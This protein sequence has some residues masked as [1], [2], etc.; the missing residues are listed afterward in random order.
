MNKVFTN[1]EKTIFSNKATLCGDKVA[2]ILNTMDFEIEIISNDINI[3]PLTNTFENL[4]SNLKNLGLDMIKKYVLDKKTLTFNNNDVVISENTIDNLKLAN[5]LGIEDH[6][7]SND[8]NFYQNQINSYKSHIL[9]KIEEYE[10]KLE[11]SNIVID[12]QEYYEAFFNLELYNKINNKFFDKEYTT[13]PSKRYHNMKTYLEQFL[14]KYRPYLTFINNNIVNYEDFEA[15]EYE[16]T[17]S[18]L[19][20][21]FFTIAETKKEPVV[22]KSKLFANILKKIENGETLE[23]EKKEEIVRELTAYEKGNIKEKINIL[24][25]KCILSAIKK[26]GEQ[27]GMIYTYIKSM[28]NPETTKL[29]DKNLLC[30]LN[31]ITRMQEIEIM[32]WVFDTD[33]NKFDTT[34]TDLKHK[35][36]NSFLNEDIEEDL[37]YSNIVSK[38]LN[39]AYYTSM[40]HTILNNADQSKFTERNL[41]LKA[42]FNLEGS[43]VSGEY[44]LQCIMNKT[45]K[46]SVIF[47]TPDME[48]HIVIDTPINIDKTENNQLKYLGK[49]EGRLI[50]KID[51]ENIKGLSNYKNEIIYV[52]S[53]N[54]YIINPEKPIVYFNV[55]ENPFLDKPIIKWYALADFKFKMDKCC[56]YKVDKKLIE[57]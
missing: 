47:I 37:K 28:Y 23:N 31:I 7:E 26:D 45:D 53:G 48:Q 54:Q 33:Y 51:V 18:T 8:I 46:G 5:E 41:K 6:V 13:E 43:S 40:L 1:T 27:D 39:L 15:Y 32:D 2:S 52:N 20:K 19:V 49:S 34:E 3:T 9:L 30:N 16:Y 25:N 11:N 10:E 29:D 55:I 42:L 21:D 38:E 44:Y 4:D 22:S 17:A 57:D 56:R 50:F 14:S 12:K 35:W 36:W 24:Y